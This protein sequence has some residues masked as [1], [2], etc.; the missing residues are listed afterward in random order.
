MRLAPVGK[1]TKVADNLVW[2]KEHDFY[3]IEKV[4]E[5]DTFW[6]RK[7]NKTEIRTDFIPDQLPWG[8]VGA[9]KYLGEDSG[10]LQPVRRSEIRGKAMVCGTTMT[11]WQSE[12]LMSKVDV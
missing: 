5:G 10:E 8:K 9:Y 11:T 3:S 4:G 7:I 6:C 2:T 1:S 12:W